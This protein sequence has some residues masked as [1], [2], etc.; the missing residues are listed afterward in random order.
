MHIFRV[1]KAGPGGGFTR[2]P[3]NNAL[4]DSHRRITMGGSINA[5]KVFED[6]TLRKATDNLRNLKI[7]KPRIA[8]KYI[9][10]E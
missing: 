8:K 9:T 5:E 7:S 1:N 2:N 6:N 3:T 4:K 10:F